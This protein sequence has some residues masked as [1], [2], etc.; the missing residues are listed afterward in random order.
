MVV[1]FVGISTADGILVCATSGSFVGIST[2]D[3]ILVGATSGSFIGISTADGIL[4][5]ATSGCF[6]LVV[7]VVVADWQ[8]VSK[9][10]VMRTGISS[11]NFI[12]LPNLQNIFRFKNRRYKR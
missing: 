4:V 12:G 1:E 10:S 11:L 2:A 3:G 8:P 9:M 7:G 6:G 5:G